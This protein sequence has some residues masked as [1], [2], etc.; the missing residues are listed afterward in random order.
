[1]TC[2]GAAAKVTII[3]YIAPK[4]STY[5]TSIGRYAFSG[6]PLENVLIPEGVTTI[7]SYAFSGK[8][9][10]LSENVGGIEEYA[11]SGTSKLTLPNSMTYISTK[12]TIGVDSVFVGDNVTSIGKDN[13]GDF[14]AKFNVKYFI[15][16]GSRTHLTFWYKNIGIHNF[17]NCMYSKDTQKKMPA[18]ETTST[19]LKLP[20]L[21]EHVAEQYELVSTSCTINGSTKE[22]YYFRGLNPNYK[23]EITYT[24]VLG[25]EE[26][27]RT[28]SIN[29]DNMEMITSLPKVISAGNVI[30]SAKTNLD[31]EE[32]KVGF[33]WRRT[34]WTDDFNSNTG[35]AYLYEGTMEGYIRNLYTEKLWK[36]RP[37]YEA[38]DGSR[39]YGE[40][41]GIDP[42]NTSYFEPT[43]HTYA[44]YSVEG[45]AANVKGYA[46]RGT[47]NVTEQGFKYWITADDGSRRAA[48]DS[49][50]V[51]DDAKTVKASGN[52]MTAQLTELEYDSNYCYVAYVKTSEGETFYGEIQSLRTGL[53]TSGIGSVTKRGTDAVEVARYNLKGH[54]IN[55]PQPGLNIIRMSD[56]T[57][58]KVFVK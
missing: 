51:P 49:Q 7:G 23:Y 24:T 15:K 56:G 4:L 46:M 3:F 12:F 57:V 44:T 17:L 34:D 42:T 29:T 41:V 22:G 8:N 5:F 43:V 14:N 33:E 55:S 21:D 13:H 53:G 38:N 35:G 28:I 54:R 27:S 25:N 58:C 36:Y 37:Y 30:V 10:V 6:C 39:Y 32:E 52:V 16:P 18:V 47:D 40:W 11:F 1:M 45:N 9:I 31:D 26:M 19:S 2:F 50:T 48:A 20:T